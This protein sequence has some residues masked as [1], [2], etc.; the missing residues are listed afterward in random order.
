MILYIL[1]YDA[2]LRAGSCLSQTA[3]FVDIQLPSQLIPFP[4]V[5]HCRRWLIMGPTKGAENK[6]QVTPAGNNRLKW[7]DV[8]KHSMETLSAPAIRIDPDIA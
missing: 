6:L 4:S 1:E 7:N 2:A 8:R 3:A 5:R